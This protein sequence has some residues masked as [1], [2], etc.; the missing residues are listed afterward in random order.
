MFKSNEYFDGNVKSIAFENS[1]GPA[2]IGVMAPGEYEFDTSTVEYMTV[3]SG[4]LTVLLPGEDDW[5]EYN[6]GDTFIV[7]K[8]SSFKVK[9]K[10]ASAYR[11]LY[12]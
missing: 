5:K 2:T 9:V 1:G 7:E 6:E 3:T 11:C 8:D 10:E 12:K 4:A